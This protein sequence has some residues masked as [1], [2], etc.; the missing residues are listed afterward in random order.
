MAAADGI[1]ELSFEAALKEL[2]GIVSRLEQGS[3]A[4]EES[5]SIY[6]RGDALR[7]HCDRLLKAAEAKVEKIRIGEGGRAV[8]ADPLDID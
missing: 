2:E 4:L 7:A 6:E 5:I 8:G 1:A 3:V